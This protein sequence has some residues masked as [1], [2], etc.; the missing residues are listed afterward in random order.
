MIQGT[1]LAGEE[2]TEDKAIRLWNTRTFLTQQKILQK[3]RKRHL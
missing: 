2:K 3:W 1:E